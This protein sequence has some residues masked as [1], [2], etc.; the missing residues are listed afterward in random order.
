MLSLILGRSG[1][2]KSRRIRQEIQ[3]AL[4][5]HQT[6]FLL[7]PEQFSFESECN[8]AASLAGPEFFRLQ[9][10]TFTR[11][12]RK[13]FESSGGPVP[14]FLDNGG[15]VLCASKDTLKNLCFSRCLISDF[16]QL[17]RSFQPPAP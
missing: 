12:A 15:K 1:S 7:V 16:H 13:I 14:R 2:G 6:V 9:V 5:E 17:K 3:Q 11:L 4:K 8:L 10:F